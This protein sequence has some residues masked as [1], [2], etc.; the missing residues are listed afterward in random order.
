MSLA[1]KTTQQEEQ[2]AIAKLTAA[3]NLIREAGSAAN[4]NLQQIHDVVKALGDM[5]GEMEN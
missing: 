4:L 2:N 3:K 5:I 1:A